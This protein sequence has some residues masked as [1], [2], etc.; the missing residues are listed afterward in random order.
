MADDAVPRHRPGPGAGTALPDAPSGTPPAT[1]SGRWSAML[2]LLATTGRLGVSET[3]E[4]LGVS[5]ATVRRDFAELARRQLVTR[6]HGGV[7]AASIA[8]ELPYRYRS[9][10]GD[11]SLARIGAKVAELV[12]PGQVVGLNGG[13]TTTA[14]ARALTAREELLAAPGLSIVT[15]ALNIAAE[16][17]LRQ[18]VRCVSLGGVARPE[19]FETTGP[20]AM[21]ALEQLWLDTAVV[22]VT[23]LTVREGAT[24]DLEDEAA[25]IRGMIA[26]AGEVVVVTTSAKLGTRGFASICGA[27][28]ITHLVTT[29]PEG[30]GVAAAEKQL[31]AMTAVGVQVHIV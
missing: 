26:R 7:V 28:Q 14:V 30:E 12:R 15:N 27:A 13:T 10:Q 11:E 4:R 2:D 6:Q 23:G 31:Q 22:G 17:V 19:S 16:A 21:Q 3:A 20:I 18:H 25:L 5:E 24:C 8:Y 1:R 29:R 9:S